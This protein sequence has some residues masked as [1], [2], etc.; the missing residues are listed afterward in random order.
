MVKKETI[1]KLLKIKKDLE[2]NCATLKAAQERL[3]KS[4]EERSQR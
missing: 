3:K 4:L 1:E 2:R